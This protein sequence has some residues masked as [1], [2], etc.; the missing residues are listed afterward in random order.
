VARHDLAKLPR[1]TDTLRASYERP[2]TG[3]LAALIVLG[4]AA[5]AQGNPAAC[6][7]IEPD[8]ARL[9]CYDAVYRSP[10]DPSRAAAP[11]A[12]MPAAGTAPAGAA[13]IPVA[14]AAAA[15]P[16]AEFGLTEKQ[17]LAQQPDAKP[18]PQ[19]IDGVVREVQ[20]IGI[21][22]WAMTL[23]NGQ[24]WTQ[25]ES[26]TRQPFKPGDSIRIREAAMNSY[27]A[28]GPKSGGSVRVRRVR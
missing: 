1:V 17:K 10:T 2:E 16:V 5:G 6:A 13:A 28:T 27:L 19:E 18:K 7:A 15:D 23:E 21:D 4:M 11:V 3:M 22:R 8:A 12:A 9:A 24:V 14:A 25:A 20:K 26:T